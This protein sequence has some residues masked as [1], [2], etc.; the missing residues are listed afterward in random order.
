[1]DFVYVK[2]VGINLKVSHRHHMCVGSLS[3]NISFMMY[4]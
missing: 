4:R 2:S 1:V 3:D